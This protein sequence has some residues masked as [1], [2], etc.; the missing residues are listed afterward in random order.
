MHIVIQWVIT[1]HLLLSLIAFWGKYF[2][3]LAE[4]E[5]KV[6]DLLGRED[7]LGQLTAQHSPTKFSHSRH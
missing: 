5:T 3:G 6:S 1:P 7:V 4:W 2:D